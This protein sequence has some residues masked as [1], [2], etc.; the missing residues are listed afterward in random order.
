MDSYE[1]ELVESELRDEIAELKSDNELLRKYITDI[2]EALEPALPMV[3]SP[4]Q[5]LDRVR[6]L[7]GRYEDLKWRMDGLEK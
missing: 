5:P 6:V 3:E 7:V 1:C 4:T 2:G